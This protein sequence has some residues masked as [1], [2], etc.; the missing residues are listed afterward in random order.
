[1]DPT[2]TT[3]LCESPLDDT[4][5]IDKLT[6]AGIKIRD[7]ALGNAQFDWSYP[8]LK[9]GLEEP[10]R[11]HQRKKLRFVRLLDEVLDEVQT[12]PRFVTDEERMITEGE[13]RLNIWWVDM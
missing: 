10:Q 4:R 9:M 11:N 8:Q 6:K 2:P 3:R 12:T 7:F 5:L 1:M 13:V